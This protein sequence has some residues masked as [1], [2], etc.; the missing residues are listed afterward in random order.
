MQS[1]ILFSE[2]YVAKRKRRVNENQYVYDVKAGGQ[3]ASS[4]NRFDLLVNV[5]V[6]RSGE[7]RGVRLKK[8][9]LSFS[10]RYKS[11]CRS[12]SLSD[13][14]LLPNPPD[15]FFQFS[16]FFSALWDTGK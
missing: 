1:H 2:K 8:T 14:Y 13:V 4:T 3:P 10:L 9:M 11:Y 12:S 7:T 6:Q 5:R 15:S 16:M